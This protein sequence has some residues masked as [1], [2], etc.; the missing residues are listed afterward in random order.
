MATLR[1]G[2]IEGQKRPCMMK[3]ILGTSDTSRKIEIDRVPAYKNYMH[4][5]F[6]IALFGLSEKRT[7]DS[8]FRSPKPH[9]LHDQQLFPTSQFGSPTTS[10]A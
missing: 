10:C 6:D 1:M 4:A 3:R 7:L 2:Y 8:E 9:L 5:M